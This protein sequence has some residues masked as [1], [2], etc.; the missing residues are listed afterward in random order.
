MTI[1]FYF[2]FFCYFAQFIYLGGPDPD[3]E[4]QPPCIEYLLAPDKQLPVINCSADC[5]PKCDITWLK[6]GG[7]QS[8]LSNNGTLRLVGSDVAGEYMCVATRNG[9]SSRNVNSSVISVFEKGTREYVKIVLCCDIH[10]I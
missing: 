3:P 7:T 2:I 5:H 6:L 1:L 9:K 10:Y 8:V 4:L